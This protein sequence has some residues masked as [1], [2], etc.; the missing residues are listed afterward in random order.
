MVEATKKSA[1]TVLPLM[2]PIFPSRA[3][4]LTLGLIAFALLARGQV[5]INEVS[6][7]SNER[8]LQWTA[9][10]VPRLGSG[11]PWNGNAFPETGWLSG[12]LPAGWGTAV[13]TNLQTAMQNKTPSLY[14]RKSFTVTAAQAASTN[15]VVLAVEY[16]DGFVAYLNGVEVARSEAVR[17][18]PDCVML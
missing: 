3:L 5:V 16:D 10:G 6:S 14:L 13:G 2:N 17:F 7:A 15:P 9:G 1:T 11:I 18:V 12:A 8:L 4:V